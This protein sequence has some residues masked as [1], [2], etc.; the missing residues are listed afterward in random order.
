MVAALMGLYFGL[1]YLLFSKLKLAWTRNRIIGVCVAGFFVLL[2]LILGWKISAPTITNGAFATGP[3]LEMRTDVSGRVVKVWVTT[4]RD[5]EKGEPLFRVDPETYRDKMNLAAAQLEQ[6]KN[7]IA[8][9]GVS[10]EGAVAKESQ[11]RQHVE[12]QRASQKVAEAQVQTTKDKIEEARSDLA[13]ARAN[14]DK[15]VAQSKATQIELQMAREAFKT[16]AVSKLQLT[17]AE[18]NDEGARA[19][20]ES[21]KAN[22]EKVRVAFEKTL[23]SQ[24]RGAVATAEQAKSSVAESED[25][26][27]AAEAQTRQLKIQLDSKIDG[28][29]TAIRQA[30]ENFNVAKWNFE[31]T[32]TYAPVDGFV[33]DPT[34]RVGTVVK[35]FDKVMSIV[36]NEERWIIAR[37][38]QYLTDFIEEGNAV[39][40]TFP[41]YPGKIFTGKLEKRLWAAGESQKTTSTIPDLNT[42]QS[43]MYYA[44]RIRMDEMPEDMPLRFGATG[45]AS[46]FTEHWKPFALIQK[47]VINMEAWMN[48]LP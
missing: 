43:S 16:N 41:L 40:L 2:I 38:P 10:Y 39:D 15:S 28:E 36:S 14:L 7:E 8:A 47:M 37:V 17:E 44:V 33:I 4:P 24:L 6:T 9:L 3:V 19:G 42:I 12:T 13:A 32:T 21:A 22:V 48:Y 18:K 27:R 35:A 1:I 34:L 30:R 5:I 26:L 29:H 23:P 45:T 20:V 31:H 11:A 46:V 25:A